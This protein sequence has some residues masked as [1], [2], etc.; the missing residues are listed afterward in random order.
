MNK[1]VLITYNW[2]DRAESKWLF[3]LEKKL[4]N[5]GFSVAL[6]AL[7]DK[8]ARKLEASQSQAFIS[9][10]QQTY[11]ISEQDTHIVEHDPGC[12]TIL[13]YLESIARHRPL[14]PSLL[15]AGSPKKR[16]WNDA[17]YKNFATLGSGKAV[18]ASRQQNLDVHF[19]PKDVS[20]LDIKLVILYGGDL[21]PLLEPQK[22]SK[23][24]RGE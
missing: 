8:A 7:S 3:W 17:P 5:K 2:D 21:V 18:S 15:I 13:K 24:L 23:F 22:E 9:E 16:H 4:I 10:L 1:N 12:L 6:A 11:A 14:V 20:H 19:F